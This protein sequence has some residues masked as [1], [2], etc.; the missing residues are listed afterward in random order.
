MIVCTTN[1]VAGFT[2]VRHLGIVH[3][4]TVRSRS[5]VGNFV[6]GIQAVFRDRIGAYLDLAENARHEAFDPM[7]THACQ[8]GANAIIGTRYD[9][10]D[11]MDGITE[12]L[13]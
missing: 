7:C 8:A 12:D 10:N 13:A 4:I 11:I 6:S 1:E 2:I 5:V 3:G 9:A